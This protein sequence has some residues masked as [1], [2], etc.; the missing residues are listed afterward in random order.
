MRRA[1]ALRARVESLFAPLPGETPRFK[2]TEGPG[3]EIVEETQREGAARITCRFPAGF[4][5]I[6]WLLRTGDLR[7]IGSEKN[8]DGAIL[9]VCPDGTLEAHVME[10]KHTIS[11]SKW[12][13]AVEQIEWTVIRLLAIAGALH[14]RVSR[15]VVYT[16]YRNDNL[17]LD[18]AADP[19]PFALPLDGPS[20]DPIVRRDLEWMGSDITLRGWASRFP[21][22]KVRK[23]DHGHATVDLRVGT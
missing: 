7:P 19:V 6:R 10:C 22:V 13:E 21:H 17:S 16:A 1:D 23:D 15:V 11:A 3:D 9:I 20:V 4:L 2:L 8:A 14:E 18:E 5:A 12:R